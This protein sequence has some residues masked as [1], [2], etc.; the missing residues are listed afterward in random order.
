MSKY[1]AIAHLN[2]K[3]KLKERFGCRYRLNFLTDHANTQFRFQF[4]MRLLGFFRG[5][6]DSTDAEQSIYKV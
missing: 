6:C 5:K 4:T 3:T 2:L 1:H